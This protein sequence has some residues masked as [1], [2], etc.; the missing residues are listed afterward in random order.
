MTR[1][2][3]PRSGYIL[4]MGALAIVLFCLSV[5]LDRQAFF[6]CWLSAWWT[7][8]GAVLGSQMNLWLH[9]L[10]GGAW[11]LPLRPI[12][13][14]AMAGL[15]MLLALMLPLIAACWLFYP[16]SDPGWTPHSRYPAFQA[17]W[18][19]PAFVTA[20]LLAY[21]ALW[22]LLS[23]IPSRQRKG[24]SAVGLIIYGLTITLAGVDLILSLMPQWHSSGFGLIALTMQMKLGFALAV[25]LG[26]APHRWQPRRH[27]DRGGMAGDAG[28]TPSSTFPGQLGRDWSNLLLMYVM[29]WAYL[30]FVQFL[31]IWAENLPN[32]I[33]WYVPRMQSG[34]AWLGIFLA[35]AGFCVPLL[36]LLLRSVKQDCRRLRAV[37]AALCVIG[38]LE[39]VW[40]I[41]PSV[42]GL[43]WHA[44]WMA[45]LALAGMAALICYMAISVAPRS[46]V[47]QGDR[48]SMRELESEP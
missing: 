11:G 47:T 15:P 36:L 48:N 25:A 33:A 20:R 26:A 30:A 39:S 44:L 42:P 6:A 1:S 10:T 3:V 17:R 9:D 16:W 38:W 13:R 35:C 18:L 43:G 24:L 34:W 29:M 27:A 32:E 28:A 2:F 45:P 21:G 4:A 22:Q 5:L 46:R 8:A 41:L 19:S 31:I 23:I 37:A 40:V 12:W 7:C 14:R